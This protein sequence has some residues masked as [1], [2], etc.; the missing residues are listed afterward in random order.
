MSNKLGRNFNDLI[1]ENQIEHS[2]EEKI[3]MIDIRKIRPNPVQPRKSFNRESLDELAS[4]I[5][6]HGVIQPVI[7]KPGSNGYILVAGERRVRAAKIAE[8]TQ[9]PAIIRDYNSIYLAELAI[10][11]NLQREDLSSIEEAL[12]FKNA[13]D[14]LKLTHE[15]LGTKIGKSRSYVTNVIGLLNLPASVI[16]L[17]NGGKI[18]MGHARSLSKLKDQKEIVLLVE[19]IILENLTVRELEN[20]IRQHKKN[21]DYKTISKDLRDYTINRVSTYLDNEFDVKINKNTLRISVK[22]ETEMTKLLSYF[23]VGDETNE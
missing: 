16:D 6:E 13:I 19:R 7:L 20:I 11:E 18:S 22:N 21:D 2:D 1:K 14:I 5:R 8:L 4:S 3:V 12:A 17:V 9:V 23:S 15:E 10:M